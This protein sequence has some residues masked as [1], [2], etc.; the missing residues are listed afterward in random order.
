[1]RA[2]NAHMAAHNLALMCKRAQKR[3]EASP[4]ARVSLCALVHTVSRLWPR[5]RSCYRPARAPGRAE[6]SKIVTSS[7][8]TR[9][10]PRPHTRIFAC[11]YTCM[12]SCSGER[13]RGD[14]RRPHRR[15]GH[16]KDN[17]PPPVGPRPAP[18]RSRLPASLTLRAPPRRPTP[19]RRQ[20]RPRP[21]E[22][23][24]APPPRGATSYGAKRDAPPPD[25][26]RSS[27]RMTRLSRRAG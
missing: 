4:R 25:A 20:S 23:G 5:A 13:T 18:P 1:M 3:V 9:N 11:M 7:E 15:E 19:G 10:G 26:P 27:R 8:G 14:A 21:R 12:R 6:F 16:A 24:A 22:V 17:L 2:T